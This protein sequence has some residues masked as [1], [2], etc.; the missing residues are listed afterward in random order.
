MNSKLRDKI[1]AFKCE[2]SEIHSINYKVTKNKKKIDRSPRVEKDEVLN[3]LPP[4]IPKNATVVFVGFNPGEESSRKQHHY[5]HPTNLFWKLFKALALLNQIVLCRDTPEDRQLRIYKE[6]FATGT[7]IARPYHDYQ[8]AELGVGFTDLC[9][10]CTKQAKELNL[11]EKLANVPRLFTEFEASRA[12]FVVIVG[13]GIWEII[14][15]FIDGKG[16]LMGFEWG[17]QNPESPV[18]RAIHHNCGYTPAIYVF[19]N[20]SGLVAL[21]KYPQKL[22]LWEQLASDVASK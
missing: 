10:R 22:Q 3:D 6:I 12:P 13:K 11:K 15:K 2:E 17:R 8:L 20:T 14:V 9:L 4:S 5:A 7:C 1:K 18:I 21:M 19:P 16:K